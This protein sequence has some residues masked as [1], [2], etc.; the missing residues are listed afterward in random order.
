MKKA[1][2]RL[3]DAVVMWFNSSPFS[4]KNTEYPLGVKQRRQNNTI[5]PVDGDAEYHI[6][7]R[8]D[9]IFEKHHG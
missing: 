2:R 8:L 4:K 6:M 5:Y 9:D 7:E 1:I 3:I